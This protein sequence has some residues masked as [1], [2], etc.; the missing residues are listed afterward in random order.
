MRWSRL[1][2]PMFFCGASPA[3]FMNF[4]STVTSHNYLWRYGLTLVVCVERHNP[5]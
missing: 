4:E 5:M 1:E 2:I 3:G